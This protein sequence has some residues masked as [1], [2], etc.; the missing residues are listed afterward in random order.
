MM[1]I[2]RMENVMIHKRLLIFLLLG[3][4]FILTGCQK[5]EVVETIEL[6]EPSSVSLVTELASISDI[7]NI[8]LY[9][10]YVVPYTKELTFIRDGIFLNYN[11]RIG[12][13]VKQGDVLA[14]LDDE[15]LLKEIE[16]I[17][18]AIRLLEE[19]QD[20]ALLRLEGDMSLKES[21]LISLKENK[22]MT[23]EDAKSIS[24]ERIKVEIEI[25]MI[26]ENIKVSNELFQ[27]EHNRLEEN[28]ARAIRS[29]NKHT[30]I[31]PFDGK[32]VALANLHKGDRVSE[33]SSII[34]LINPSDTRVTC[35]F[36]TETQINES[37][38]YYM[39]KNGK[40]YDVTY[41][42]Y[43]KDVYAALI[44]KQETPTSTFL[45]EGDDAGIR[46]G[47]YV[48]ICV[49]K[50]KIED[51]LTIP[52]DTLYKDTNGEYVYV[53]E[54]GLKKKKYIITGLADTIS[55]EVKEGLVEGDKVYA[56]N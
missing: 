36:I 46:Q 49:V 16:S 35:E 7:T 1:E 55:V 2:N 44:L 45:Y 19:Q 38:E 8:E 54:N 21:N 23:S 34:G 15:P 18:E 12:D 28:L 24:A 11:V 20:Q 27:I 6:V 42:P 39:Y 33:N 31:A 41:L 25:Q 17:K 47:D 51:V 29:S 4:L 32:V 50:N 52:I 26:K 13:M 56:E 37:L 48:L 22:D 9:E 43:D 10:A 30:I 53:D 14:E 5:S 3:T 40:K